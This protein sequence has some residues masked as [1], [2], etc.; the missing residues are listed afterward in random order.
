LFMDELQDRI[1]DPLIASPMKGNEK[2]FIITENREQCKWREAYAA[3]EHMM[4]LGTFELIEAH[5]TY[6]D[7]EYVFIQHATITDDVSCSKIIEEIS[8]NATCLYLNII[9]KGEFFEIGPVRGYRRNSPEV[10][11]WKKNVLNRDNHTCQCCG[12]KKHLEVHHI[13]SFTENPHLRVDV[14]NGIVLCKWCHGKYHSLYGIKGANPYD[15][16]NFLDRFKVGG[17]E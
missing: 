14:N 8:D 1:I 7:E 4:K 11:E 2:F 3:L 9:I 16:V 12:V 5:V 17:R 6:V 15:F 13:S 10:R